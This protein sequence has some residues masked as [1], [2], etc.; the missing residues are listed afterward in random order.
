MDYGKLTEFTT[1]QFTPQSQTPFFRRQDKVRVSEGNRSNSGALARSLCRQSQQA[2]PWR[3]VLSG[4]R[5]RR[6]ISPTR[7]ENN[8]EKHF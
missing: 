3:D 5:R 8:N 7:K 6:V 4:E 1:I 2:K